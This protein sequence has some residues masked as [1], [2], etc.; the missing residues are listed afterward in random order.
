MVYICPAAFII[1]LLKVLLPLFWFEDSQSTDVKVSFATDDIFSAL[2][3]YFAICIPGKNDSLWSLEYHNL[4]A[5][6]AAE[7]AGDY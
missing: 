2:D 7:V 6:L 3:A 1:N 5:I 4:L